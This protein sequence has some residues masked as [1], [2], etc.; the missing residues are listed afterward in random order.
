MEGLA[1]A[2]IA[3]HCT[4]TSSTCSFEQK[5]AGSSV[6]SSDATTMCAQA[7]PEKSV[8]GSRPAHEVKEDEEHGMIGVCGRDRLN[9][10]CLS[11]LGGF[12]L[13]GCRV[14]LPI[15]RLPCAVALQDLS[16]LFVGDPKP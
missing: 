3:S 6:A 2:H 10:L 14:T 1:V 5:Q 8:N 4:F 15:P 9:S 16:E 11:R 7:L 12:V 13:T